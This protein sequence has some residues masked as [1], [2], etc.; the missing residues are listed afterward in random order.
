MDV[1]HMLT[2]SCWEDRCR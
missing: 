1:F 2:M